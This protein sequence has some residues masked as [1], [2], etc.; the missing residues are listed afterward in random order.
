MAKKE[1][2]KRRNILFQEKII[3]GVCFNWTNP[4]GLPSLSDKSLRFSFLR[5]SR[6]LCSCMRFSFSVLTCS[7]VWINSWHSDWKP[8]VSFFSWFTS[9]SRCLSSSWT[10]CGT[11]NRF[12]LHYPLYRWPPSLGAG[13]AYPITWP[14]WL[15]SLGE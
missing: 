2:P 15:V 9:V 6:F 12:F 5:F 4:I 13:G 11:K 3:V 1:L 7:R 8:E 14:M 10:C